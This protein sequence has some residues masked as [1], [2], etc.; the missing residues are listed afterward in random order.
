VSGYL[1]SLLTRAGPAVELDSRAPADIEPS[2]ATDAASEGNPFETTVYDA[3]TWPASTPIGRQ[4]S[5]P[6]QVTRPEADGP[7][8][9]VPVEPPTRGRE[10]TASFPPPRTTSEV[11]EPRV[12]RAVERDEVPIAQ[13]LRPAAE[14]EPS[15]ADATIETPGAVA[16]PPASR[17]VDPLAIADRFL[18]QVLPPALL[19][20]EVRIE[21]TREIARESSEP[22]VVPSVEPRVLEPP[23]ASPA[24]LLEP[25]APSL[26]IGSLR[27]NVIPPAPAAVA[28]A[29]RATSVPATV[30]IRHAGGPAPGVPSFSRFG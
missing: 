5:A 30:V 28:P 25:P 11:A 26:V 13:T 22:I 18:A 2:V 7:T 9:A 17:G 19:P 12:I 15:H 24:D 4:V 10:H 16:E 27:V 14:P 6:E 20:P 1:A 21:T 29:P 3:P 23:I 8:R